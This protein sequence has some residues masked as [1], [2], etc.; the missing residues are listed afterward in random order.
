MDIDVVNHNLDIER[1][2]IHLMLSYLDV[3]N[4]MCDS[5]FAIDYFSHEHQPLVRAIYKEYLDSNHKR[6]LTRLSYRNHLIGTGMI[7]NN[8]YIAVQVHDKCYHG[9]DADFNDFGV[10]KKQLIEYFV[11]TQSHI[12]LSE[13]SKDC[14]SAGFVSAAKNLVNKMQSVVSLT[15]TRKS[16][17]ASGAD[18]KEEYLQNLDM[19]RKN[20]ELAIRCGIEEIDNSITVG[21]RPQHL[22]L[23][24]ADVGS[25]KTTIMINVA[26]NLAD[27]GHGVLFIPLEMNRFDL[28]HRIVANRVGI[29]VS[30]LSNP[31]QLSDEQIELIQQSEMWVKS[32]K[33]FHILD[34]DER[35]SVSTLK[36]EIEAKAM[37]FKPKVVIIDY[38]DNLESDSRYGQRYIEIGEI[39]KSLRFLGKQYGFHIISAAQMNRSAIKAWKSGNEDA[40]DSTAIYGSHQYSADSDTIFAITKMKDED[41][42]KLYTIKA[43]HGPSGQTRELRVDPARC[44]ITS[45]SEIDSMSSLPEFDADDILNT[46]S[47]DIGKGSDVNVVNFAGADDL[48][49]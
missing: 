25:Y 9:T 1:K 13:Y 23:F 10:L 41:K 6:L 7:K 44:Q 11:A 29:D 47:D 3:V 28:M 8:A 48:I 19:F 20:P 4:E 46:S 26:L 30:L 18:L 36:H 38:V 21:F 37:T 12:C 39:L 17:Y 32:Q 35:T 43:R 42:I 34:A 24:V 15:E 16:F 33:Y 22:T 5:G 31:D 2:I 27:N 45:I 14:K 40:M 49:L